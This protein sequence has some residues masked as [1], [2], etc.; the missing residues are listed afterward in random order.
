[1]CAVIHGDFAPTTRDLVIDDFRKGNVKV[2]ICSNMVSRG[3]D[4]E[5]VNVVIN[6]D[7]PLDVRDQPDPETYLHRI[8][9]TGRFG[10]S[11]ISINL[12]HDARSLENMKA[13]VEHFGRPVNKIEFDSLSALETRLRDVL[14]AQT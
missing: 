7:I 13:I 3:L 12:V 14:D 8:G 5:Q 2:L 11:G 1:M 4:I 6:F 9:R 10:R